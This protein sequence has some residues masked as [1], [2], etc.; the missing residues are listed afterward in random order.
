MRREVPLLICAIVGFTLIIV[1]FVPH[2]PFSDMRDLFSDWFSVIAAFAIYL[3]ILNLLKNSVD[4]VFR[5]RS[6]WGFSIVIIAGFVLFVFIGLY[7]GS[8]FGEIGTRYYWLYDRIY[9]PLMATMFAILAFFIG[10]ASY[11][12][13]RARNVEATV[14][15]LAA[16]FVM[17]GR[18]PIGYYL[19]SWLPEGWRMGDVANAIMTYPQM[20]GQRAVMIGIALGIVSTSLRIILGIE[21]TFL[22]GE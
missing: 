22:G 11:R 7:E 10:S 5:K 20:A 21:R 19:T 1:Y 13:F 16:F 9:F 12:A 8:D 18:V 15:L 17:L 3:G 6:G 14:L 2:P 4:K